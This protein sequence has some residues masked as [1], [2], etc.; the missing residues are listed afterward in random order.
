MP[1]TIR[2]LILSCCALATVAANAQPAPCAALQKQLNKSTGLRSFMIKEGE[3]VNG[4]RPI[5]NVDIDGDGTPERIVVTRPPQSD[6]FPPEQSALSIVL[7]AT[8][9]ELRTEFHRLFLVRFENIVYL[10]GSKLL[11]PQGPVM[12]DVLRVEKTG[13]AAACQYECNLRGGCRP[14][15]EAKGAPAAPGR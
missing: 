15:G 4:R 10:V 13:F 5:A 11:D 9:I 3:A 6:R 2:L 12:T 14:R 7:S 1:V 8:Q